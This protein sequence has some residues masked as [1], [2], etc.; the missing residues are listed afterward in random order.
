MAV[1]N[2]G[3]G[4]SKVAQGVITASP[5]AAR[6]DGVWLIGEAWGR[7]AASPNVGLT[8]DSRGLTVTGPAPGQS[9]TLPWTWI[10][11][12]SAGAPMTFPDGS[13]ATVVEVGLIGRTITLL[14]PPTQ[15]RGDEIQELNR[16]VPARLPPPPPPPPQPL[17][18]I[19]D[20][21]AYSEIRSS[22][23][24]AESLSAETEPSKKPKLVKRNQGKLDDRSFRLALLLAMLV[25]VALVGTVVIA[26]R[27]RDNNNSA[28]APLIVPQ[29]T[30]TTAPPA[31]STFSGP[32]AS[33]NPLD[34]ADSVNLKLSDLPSGWGN[35]KLVHIKGVPSPFADA[36]SK[37]DA[38]L[39]QC[40]GMPQS[41][42]GIVTGKTESGGPTVWPSRI[43][44]T[45]SPFNPSAVSVST[46]VQSTA[47]EQADLAALLKLGSAHCFDVYYSTSFA[48]EH[49]VS[50]P[51]VN[52]FR[53]PQHAGEEVIGLDVHIG[54][55][56]YGRPA[57]YDYDVVVI[58][59]GRLEVALGAQQDDEPF[60]ESTLNPALEAIEARAASVAG[61]H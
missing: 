8:L 34:V 61:G 41:Q 16:Y 50:A 59:A 27:I 26:L 25:L 49:I 57:V 13:P 29:P 12:F 31:A 51:L 47:V 36:Q 22:G 2:G 52:Q 39:A 19:R 24:A 21:P 60:P 45:N 28:N 44:V 5:G 15:L 14:V 1:S 9:S 30:E 38:A 40:L 37:A 20:D 53:V 46:L 42:V 3:D 6:F 10:Q 56:L 48:S 58:G 11:S 33:A 54:I 18:E 55:L 17:A 43:F 23:V 32:P 4:E 7:Q 35:V